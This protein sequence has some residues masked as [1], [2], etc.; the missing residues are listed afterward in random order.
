VNLALLGHGE[1]ALGA[2]AKERHEGMR[3]WAAA[4]AEW[5]LGRKAESEAAL[6]ELKSWPKANAWYLAQ[7]Y[8]LQG[9]R[10]QAFEWLEKA[11]ME[12][13]GG[14]ETLKIDRFLR[15]LRD[16]GRY[17]ALLAKMKLD[18]DPPASAR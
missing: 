8:A 12:P 2:I 9:N 7:L 14:C 13:Q 5:S 18:G 4:I 1:H 11:C 15:G 3:L 17:R 6:A 16:D 10:G